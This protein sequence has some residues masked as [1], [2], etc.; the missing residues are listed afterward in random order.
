MSDRVPPRPDLPPDGAPVPEMP[1]TER[2]LATWQWWEAILVYLLI[3]IVSAVATFPIFQVIRSRGLA[4]LSASAIIAIVNVGLLVLWLQVFH[5][6]WRRV[7]GFPRRIW[8]EVR[9]GTGFGALLYPVVVFGVGIVLNLLLQLITGR[10]IRS[11]RQ[12]PAHLSTA[13][14]AV[15]IAYAVVIAPIHEEL[16]FRGILFRSLADR[17]G[18]A[19]GAGGSGLAF[20]L[21]HY[22]PGP[23]YGSVLLMGVMVFTGVALAWFYERRGNIVANMVAHATFNVIGLTLILVLR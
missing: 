20:G 6:R 12:L 10:S 4:N 22:V 3:L 9:A 15:S 23:V 8:P 11:P 7:I 16:F 5:P 17:Y 2:P 18:F 13:G 21:I 1:P 19:I 14:V